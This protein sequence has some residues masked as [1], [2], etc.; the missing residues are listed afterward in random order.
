MMTIG[1]HCRIIGR[2]GRFAA[3]K[4]FVEEIGKKEGVWV[5]TRTEIAEAF[6]K[7]YPYKKGQL[8]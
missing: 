8:A 5:A 7:E 1:L 2:P 6:K 4:K 3:L